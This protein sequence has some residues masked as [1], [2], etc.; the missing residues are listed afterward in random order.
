MSYRPTV[1]IAVG[2]AG[3]A[4]SYAGPGT[5]VPA[6]R[7]IVVSTSAAGTGVVPEGA[8]GIDQGSEAQSR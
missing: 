5:P 3:P 1:R 2:E 7:A 8:G 6:R 4:T